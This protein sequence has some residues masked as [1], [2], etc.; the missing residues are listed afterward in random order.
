MA[1][2]DFRWGCFS[3]LVIEGGKDGTEASNFGAQVIAI[4]A[5]NRNPEAAFQLIQYITQ[6][7]FDQKM[8][9]YSVGIPADSR[10]TE[11]PALLEDVKPVMES[12]TV[13]YPWAAGG[14]DNLDMTPI[15]KENFL[16]ICGGSLDAEGFVAALK[17]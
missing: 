5:K 16:K 6:G 9:E 3:Y 15:I 1:G 14:E 7:E 8:S 11:W 10:N 13:R 2:P 12:L 17:K 4:N